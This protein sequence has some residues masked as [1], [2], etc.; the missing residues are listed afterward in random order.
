MSSLLCRKEGESVSTIEMTED[1]VIFVVMENGLKAT[2]T[3]TASEVT[4]KASKIKL[5]GKEL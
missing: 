3:T 5:N 1:K 2:V 4:L